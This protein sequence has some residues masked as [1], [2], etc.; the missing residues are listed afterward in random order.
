LGADYVKDNYYNYG[1][2]AGDVSGGTGQGNVNTP[3]HNAVV[4]DKINYY[5]EDYVSSGGAF[6]QAEYSKKNLTVFTTVSASDLGLK[7]TDFFNYLN[8]D[9]NRTSPSV[10]FFTYQAKAGANYNINSQMNIFAN[11]GYLTKPPYYGNVFEDYTNIINKSAIT[12][13]SFSYELGYG[14]KTSSFSANLNLYRTSYMDKAQVDQVTDPNTGQLY[15]INISGLNEMHQGAELELK[16]RPIKEIILGGTLSLGDWYYSSNS[17]PAAAYDNTGALVVGSSRPSVPIKGLKLGDA[18]QTTAAV[19]ADF[20]V[21]PQLKVGSIFNYWGNYTAYVPFT[22]IPSANIQPYK[23]PD[24]ATWDLNA[25]LKFKMAGFDAIL[26]GTVNN[27]LNT[28]F[29][30]DASD[31]GPKGV[32]GQAST[33][34]VYYGLGRT[35]TTGLKIKF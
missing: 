8:S 5:N 28:K 6:A 18:A 21:L 1:A 29:I 13:K 3:I 35:F 19:I 26:S 10:N 33:V 25:S 20:Y 24:Y 9:P 2:A 16:Y 4:G 22:D 30:S 32:F 14:Y 27:L 7:R 23:I 11:I 31:D 34:G 17:G 15:E 12:E